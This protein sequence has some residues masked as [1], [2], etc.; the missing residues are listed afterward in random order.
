M[1]FCRD[2]KILAPSKSTVI[3]MKM[4]E[5]KRDCLTELDVTSVEA[6]DIKPIS[7]RAI[8]RRVTADTMQQMSLGISE[9]VCYSEIPAELSK[10]A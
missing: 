3:T 6:M 5:K 7:C 9:P 2:W 10:S 8:E 1:F 4:T